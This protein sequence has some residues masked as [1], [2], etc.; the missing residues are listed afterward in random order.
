MSYTLYLWKM[1]W[2]SNLAVLTLSILVLSSKFCQRCAPDGYFGGHRCVGRRR[3]P[4]LMFG[5]LWYLLTLLPVIGSIKLGDAGM[6]DRY[7]YITLIGP[8]VARCLGGRRPRGAVDRGPR[9]CA[10][11]G[12]RTALALACL[13]DR[14]LWPAGTLAGQRHPVH[15]TRLSSDGRATSWPTP[16]SPAP[17]IDEGTGRGRG[18]PAS[19]DGG[20]DQRPPFPGGPLQPRRLCRASG[21]EN[22]E[23]RGAWRPSGEP[24]CSSDAA[25]FRRGHPVRWRASFICRRG[26]SADGAVAILSEGP[27]RARAPTRR[28]FAT[29]DLPRR[30]AIGRG[31]EDEALSYSLRTR[32]RAGGAA[33]HG[34]ALEVSRQRRDAFTQQGVPTGPSGHLR[35][36]RPAHARLRP[37]A[38]QP[39]QRLPMLKAPGR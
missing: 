21:R 33:D 23:R 34:A 27:W 2:P 36:G 16:V 32:A 14:D 11:A 5:W 29:Q 1:I 24:R 30:L 18:P 8:F 7:S 25:Y 4:Y 17:L 37:G 28:P 19:R 9:R 31:A 10:A 6:A 3:F 39:R 22:G 15:A 20:K 12:P 26:E 13:R 35:G 38:Q